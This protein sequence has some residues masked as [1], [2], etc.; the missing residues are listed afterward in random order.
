M[1]S[2]PS[3]SL[4]ID[5]GNPQETREIRAVERMLDAVK[6]T[7]L[8]ATLKQYRSATK[9]IVGR[10]VAKMRVAATKKA[11]LEVCVTFTCWP[12]HHV[13]HSYT[14]FFFSI[15]CC[16]R[17]TKL[18]TNARPRRSTFGLSSDKKNSAAWRKKNSAP[19]KPRFAF[20]DCNALPQITLLLLSFTFT[21][22]LAGDHA[23]MSARAS[24]AG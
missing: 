12:H 8:R 23:D 20:T 21:L 9:V 6:E 16:T 1:S 3:G 7:A 14:S 17:P 19:L 13:V 11:T 18:R 4:R 5:I 10:Q 24:H 22:R 15:T 2:G